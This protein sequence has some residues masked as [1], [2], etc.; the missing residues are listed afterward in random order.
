MLQMNV[1]ELERVRGE[2]LGLVRQRARIAALIAIV[3][4][5]GLDVA[6]DA[7]LLA[8]LLPEITERFGLS[9]EKIRQ[10]PTAQREQAAWQMRSRRPGFAGQV[11]SP[12]LLRRRLGGQFGRLLFTQ[13]AKFIPLTG[14]AVAGWLGYA[15][16]ARVARRYIDDCH[17]VA[18]MLWR[19]QG[20][21]PMPAG[22]PG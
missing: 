6:A 7:R 2:C 16:V 12:V 9:P 14:S 17:E 22:S 4:V 3:P 15:V 1:A 5:P 10:M 20:A 18:T 13:V 21:P 11:A 19:E 8:R